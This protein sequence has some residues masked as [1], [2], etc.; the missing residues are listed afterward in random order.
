MNLSEINLN[1]FLKFGFFLD[2]KNPYYSFDFSNVNKSRYEDLSEEELIKI[3]IGYLKKAIAKN[4]QSGKQYIVPISGGIDSRALLATMIEFTDS[5]NLYT[6]TYGTPGTLDF[7]IGNYIAKKAGTIH[8]N[9]PLT[10]YT[11]KLDELIE[12][13]KKIDHQT[14]LFCHPPVLEIEKDFQ[15]IN[16][17]SGFGG[18]PVSGSHTHKSPSQD[19]IQAKYDFIKFNN[20]VR[21]IKLTNIEDNQYFSYIDE[22]LMGASVLPMEEEMDCYNRQLKYIAPHV[23]IKGCNYITPFLE[24]EWFDFMY[25]I[26]NKYRINQYLYKKILLKSY[27]DLFKLKTKTNYGLPLN[28]KGPTVLFSKAVNKLMKLLSRYFYF[29]KDPY[30]NYIDFNFEI[31]NRQD[32]KKIIYE[33][34]MNLRNRKIVDWID[35]ESIWKNHINR[36]AEHADALIV[37]ASLEIHIRASSV[38]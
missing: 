38:K 28:V 12:I 5:K 30:T 13:S 15:G 23:L 9:Y 37:L 21:S 32:L 4:F 10:E 36:I 6:Y 22:P 33:S 31:I 29:I 24:R 17:V 2:Y 25:S 19:I 27:K 1:S 8:R 16:I 34:I 18:G 20:F 26:D 7:E 35:I 11:Y 14:M 3:G